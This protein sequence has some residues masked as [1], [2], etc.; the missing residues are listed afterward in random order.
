MCREP[1][2]GGLGTESGP[3]LWGASLC[4]NVV[5]LSLAWFSRKIWV[6]WP[7]TADEGGGLGA[8]GLSGREGS[9]WEE[10]LLC[11]LLKGG[12][13]LCSPAPRTLGKP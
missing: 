9:V 12:A 5:C 11:G 2:R 1:W 8:V 3:P 6:R 10:G 13:S 4:T 7:W